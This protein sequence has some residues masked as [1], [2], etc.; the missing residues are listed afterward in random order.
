MTSDAQSAEV[1]EAAFP[2]S[3]DLSPEDAAGVFSEALDA[4][5]PLM[6]I[7]TWLVNDGPLTR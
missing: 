7:R 3:N 1:A 5:V 4:S 6:E 2:S